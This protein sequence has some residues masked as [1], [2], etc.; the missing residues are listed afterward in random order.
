MGT[1][2]LLFPATDN[3][4]APKY[5]ESTLDLGDSLSDRVVSLQRVAFVLQDVVGGNFPSTAYLPFCLSLRMNGSWNVCNVSNNHALNHAQHVPAPSSSLESDG[6]FSFKTIVSPAS[7]H[8]YAHPTHGGLVGIAYYDMRLD[9]DLGLVQELP[10][11]LRAHVALF[12]CEGNMMEYMPAIEIV[13][14][15]Q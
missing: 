14:H 7:T 6:H 12:N 15:I 9:Y 3:L 5:V 4:G 2:R 13:L 8:L 11:F 10:R 1:V